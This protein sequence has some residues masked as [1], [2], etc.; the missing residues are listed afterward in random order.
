M[1]EQITPA[2][3]LSDLATWQEE[4][5]LNDDRASIVEVY[6][7]SSVWDRLIHSGLPRF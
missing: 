1:C 3:H 7:Q 5:K 2:F 4:R 6:N